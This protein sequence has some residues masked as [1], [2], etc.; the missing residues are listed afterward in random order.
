[1]EKVNASVGFTAIRDSTSPLVTMN[2]L[3]MAI[4][5]GLL[6]HSSSENI[7]MV[8]DLDEPDFSLSKIPCRKLKLVDYKDEEMMKS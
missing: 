2:R 6:N 8:M 5:D 3:V 1:M 4:N 7:Q